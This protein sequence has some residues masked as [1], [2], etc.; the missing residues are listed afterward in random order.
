ML[1][2]SAAAVRD[3]S[4]MKHCVWESYRSD[5]IHLNART[6]A[7]LR[8]WSDAV[9][10]T[11]SAPY[12]HFEF[13]SPVPFIRITRV[14]L[15]PKPFCHSSSEHLSGWSRSAFSVWEFIDVTSKMSTEGLKT[16]TN[17]ATQ[18]WHLPIFR[19]LRSSGIPYSKRS[20]LNQITLAF[21]S[22]IKHLSVAWPR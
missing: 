8:R 6:R 21:L 11:L 3:L 17:Y 9:G 1:V 7:A 20:S 19:L 18:T 16:R 4:G 15:N 2:G 10:S 12:F 14:L 22:L 13:R 5:N